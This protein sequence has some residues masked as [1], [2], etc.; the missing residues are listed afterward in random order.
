MPAR[1]H[2]AVRQPVD[3]LVRAPAPQHHPA[4]DDSLLRDLHAGAAFRRP[5]PRGGRCPGRTRAVG[6]VLSVL[7]RVRSVDGPRVVLRGTPGLP[8]T[9][10]A[11]RRSAQRPPLPLLLVLAVWILRGRLPPRRRSVEGQRGVVALVLSHR[12]LQRLLRL[13]AAPSLGRAPTELRRLLP[14]NAVVPRARALALL[15]P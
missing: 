10:A 13:A 1:L 3:A 2:G 4:I 14:D 6:C 5:A 11:F 8:A 7:L 12:R 15:A 9:A